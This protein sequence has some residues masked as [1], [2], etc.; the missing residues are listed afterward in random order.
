MARS[1][2][3]YAKINLS[4]SITKK[5]ED[6]YHELDGIMLP[7]ELHDTLIISKLKNED[8]F[9]TIDD[10][11]NGLIHYNLVSTAINALAKK[12]KF[13]DRFRVFIHKVIPMQAGL[14]GGSSNAAFTLKAVNQMLKLNASD[15]ELIKIATPLGADIPFFINCKPARCKGI[16]EQIE[17]VE[18][19]NNYYVLIVKPKSGCS[20]KEVFAI[21]DKVP[22]KQIDIDK[23]KEALANGDDD[24]LAELIGNSLEE[25]AISL[26][27]EI[28]TIKD[29]LKELGLKIVLMTGSGSAVFALSTDVGLLKKARKVLEDEYFAEIAKV[30]KK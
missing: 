10:F 23:V 7:I 21:T 4:L 28:Q 6:G 16:G 26:V 22:Y 5:R 18:V 25:A 24:L 29:T 2:K 15:E 17:N 30:I 3:S 8:N 20:T 13:N 14:G 9:V 11:S 1:V 19:K 12:Y 27:P